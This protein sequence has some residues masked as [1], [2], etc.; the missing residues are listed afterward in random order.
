MYTEDEQRILDFMHNQTFKANPSSRLTKEDFEDSML[1]TDEFK[2][3]FKEMH[4]ENE[5][6]KLNNKF[7]KRL[8]E[9]GFK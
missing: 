1:M 5:N 9:R 8:K 4:R 6:I 7:Q 2:A 3:K